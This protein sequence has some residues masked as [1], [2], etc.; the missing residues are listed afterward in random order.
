MTTLDRSWDC[1]GLCVFWVPFTGTQHTSFK[2]PDLTMATPRKSIPQMWVQNAI[3]VDWFTDILAF[4]LCSAQ[5]S[6]RH[7]VDALLLG[8]CH[9]LVWLSSRCCLRQLCSV[10]FW[11]SPAAR[12]S[13]VPSYKSHQLS[14]PFDF[15]FCQLCKCPPLRWI[16][17]QSALTC[18]LITPLL[19]LFPCCWLFIFWTLLKVTSVCH[20]LYSCF[21][22]FLLSVLIYIQSP[23]LLS[24]VHL[25]P[26]WSPP[27]PMTTWQVL[28]C[29]GFC[30]FWL[31]PTGAKT[32]SII[33]WRWPRRTTLSHVL[34]L[35]DCEFKT[36][37]SF[38]G[39]LSSRS[40]SFALLRFLF[41]V[42]PTPFLRTL[43]LFG[44]YW[45]SDVTAASEN[46]T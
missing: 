45:S 40:W 42:L 9:H 20:L 36:P 39:T 6:P 28:R 19:P 8:C 38:I 43:F 22:W 31:S 17:F 25:I 44:P 7:L 15:V 18:P 32:S 30:C 13:M 10:S 33:I 37:P 5:V 4:V 16:T 24:R 35:H 2:S 34:V 23:L 14:V 1:L 46:T 27:L 29:L 41:K 26:F 21:K 12:I 11:T 3:I